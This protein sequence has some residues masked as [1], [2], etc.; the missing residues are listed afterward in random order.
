[1]A[2]YATGTTGTIGQHLSDQ[3]I[4]LRIDLQKENFVK[5]LPNFNLHDSLIHLGGIV[6]SQNVDKNINRAYQ[7]NVQ[8]TIKLAKFFLESNGGLFV[9][10]SSSHVY[11]NSLKIRDE[12]CPVNP[13]TNYAKQKLEA[14]L[15]LM[16][17][18][19][20]YSEKLCIVRVFSVLDWNM[21]STTLG[22]C[23][24]KLAE[25]NSDSKLKYGDDVRDFL[26]PKIVAKSME[27]ISECRTLYGIVNLCSGIGIKV[28]DAAKIMLA[29]FE[30][31]S[32]VQRIESGNSRIPSIVGDNSKLKS[33][34]S[35]INLKW[36][37]TEHN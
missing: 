19:S 27:R 21:E 4:P 36:M 33:H 10:V 35:N 16:D 37:P 34:I 9:Y 26:T 6:G 32:F 18:F 11:E 1:M 14:E 17:L 13:I 22:G 29:D 23:I 8:G 7:V 3:V 20:G 15:R 2:K 5:S 25:V 24:A 28:S 12:S 30:L 31:N